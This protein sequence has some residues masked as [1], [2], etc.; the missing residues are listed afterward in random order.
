METDED[1]N[2]RDFLDYHKAQNVL[3]GKMGLQR[4]A[5]VTKQLL[6]EQEKKSP[7]KGGGK[8]RKKKKQSHKKK[9][10]SHK[11]KK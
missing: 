1:N 3:G 5:N 9:K 11:K 8:K 4:V 7:P 6:A 10:R 2:S